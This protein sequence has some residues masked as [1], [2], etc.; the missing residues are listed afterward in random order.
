MDLKDYEPG[1]DMG[2]DW[3]TWRIIHLVDEVNRLKNLLSNYENC[4]DE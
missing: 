1:K 4:E 3:Y 2:T